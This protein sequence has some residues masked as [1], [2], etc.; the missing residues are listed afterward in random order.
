[1]TLIGIDEHFL[2]AE[3]REARNAIGLDAVDPSVAFHSGPIEVRLCDLAKDRLALMDG[4][5]MDETGLDVRVLSLTMPAL[6]DLGPESDD[7]ARR[8]NDALAAVARHPTRLHAQEPPC[9]GER[10]VP[11]QLSRTRRCYRRHGSPP[12]LD[13]LLLP[14]SSRSDARQFMKN[15]DLDESARAAF[16]HGSW[17][18]L[19]GKGAE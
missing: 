8:A 14:V 10:H 2:T 7:M 4:T 12:L 19:I 13:R 3:T 11:S 17:R 16:A 18:C 1:M 6:H 5:G 9:H 15:C